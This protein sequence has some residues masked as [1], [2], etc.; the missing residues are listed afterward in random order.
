MLSDSFWNEAGRRVRRAAVAG[1][2]VGQTRDGL[3][4]RADPLCEAAQGAVRRGDIGDEVLH[5][6]A[7][8]EDR[9]QLEGVPGEPVDG[10][11]SAV[12]A[13]L[14]ALAFLDRALAGLGEGGHRLLLALDEGGRIQA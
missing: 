12:Q 10:L 1:H 2:R 9:E 13:L 5:R 14:D 3:R 6:A 11:G 4:G 8:R 7:G